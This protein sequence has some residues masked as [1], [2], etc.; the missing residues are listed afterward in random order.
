MLYFFLHSQRAETNQNSR[1]GLATAATVESSESLV[2]QNKN[3]SDQFR[4][5]PSK[6]PL[7][8]D[9]AQ[10]HRGL[11][12]HAAGHWH[13]SGRGVLRL[14]G[15]SNEVGSIVQLGQRR[16][17]RQ[18]LLLLV[19][20]LLQ[21]WLLPVQLFQQL[22]SNRARPRLHVPGRKRQGERQH[23]CVSLLFLWDQ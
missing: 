12:R 10:S 16:Q 4:N 3:D 2:C 21:Y 18:W 5:F 9:L 1:F 22:S 11:L 6:I 20:L 13:F 15:H 19:V 17:R 8:P 23:H 7:L 14:C